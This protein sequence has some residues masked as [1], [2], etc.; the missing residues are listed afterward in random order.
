MYRV[1][2]SEGA[3]VEICAVVRSP[4]VSCPIQT[5]VTVRFTTRDDTASMYTSQ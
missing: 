4:T 1:T 5:P 2:E 3:T